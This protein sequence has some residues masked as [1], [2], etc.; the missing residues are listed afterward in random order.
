M[1]Y[2]AFIAVQQL[3]HDVW[4]EYLLSDEFSRIRRFVLD[5]KERKILEMRVQGMSI[6]DI[7]NIMKTKQG[8]MQKE[9]TIKRLC[10]EIKRKFRTGQRHRVDN[11]PL[12]R[13]A[14]QARGEK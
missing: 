11:H 14:K 6:Q 5:P 8:G 13:A 4:E 1:T 2:E 9:A 3:E 7:C 10:Y 12:I